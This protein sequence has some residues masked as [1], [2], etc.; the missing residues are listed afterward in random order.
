MTEE[1]NDIRNDLSG[2][3]KQYDTLLDENRKLSSR[4]AQYRKHTRDLIER[5]KELN[6]LYTI[7]DLTNRMLTLESILEGA[8]AIIPAAMQY[9]DIAFACIEWDGKRYSSDPFFQSP[10]S[11]GAQISAP[12]EKPG[13]VEVFY[14]ETGMV[15][16]EDLFLKEEKKLIDEIALQLGNVVSRFIADRKLNDAR[17]ELEQKS[18]SLE[19]MNTALKVLLDHQKN[20]KANMEKNI[21][22]NLN[23]LVF[24]YL[25][26]LR[27]LAGEGDEKAYIEIIERNI[28]EITKP[29]A[30]YFSDLTFS[31]TPTEIQIARM[32]VDNFNTKDISQ[33]LNVSESA[34]SFHRKNIRVKL[35]LT[36]RKVNLSSYLQELFRKE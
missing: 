19:E 15:S 28:G 29:F 22:A 6:C 26:K 8:A 13:W 2:L 17:R 31:L 27:A 4:E 24:P 7:S 32:I 20:D 23:I 11:Y 21:L 18:R 12:G 1:G 10:L 3:K 9:P 25:E 33:V 35:G 30:K 14:R 34:V 36:R 16:R 5:V